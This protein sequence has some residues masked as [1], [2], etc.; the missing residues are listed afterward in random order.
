[1]SAKNLDKHNRWRNKTV[2]FRVSPEEDAQ[3]ETAVKL[4]GLTKQDYIIRRL[5]CRDVVV[6][7]N[8]RVYKA[9]RDQLAAVLDELRR[10]E[11]GQSV[12]D[13]LLDTIQMITT[14]M[15]E[16]SNSPERDLEELYRKMLRMSD[17]AYLH[18]VTLDELMDNV[19][20]GKSAVIENLLYTGAYILAGAPKIGKSFLVAQIAHHVSTGQEL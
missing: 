4:T 1:M 11:A 9:L 3:I 5:L 12:N 13:E 17:P 8:P 15:N 16:K 20:E 19:F 10:I 18:T 6:Q 7:G 14:I 2:A